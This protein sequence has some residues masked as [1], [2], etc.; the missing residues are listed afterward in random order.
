[1]R[2]VHDSDKLGVKVFMEL[3]SQAQ[4]KLV[5]IHNELLINNYVY[6]IIELVKELA[7]VPFTKLY[8]NITVLYPETMKDDFKEL[9]LQLID[10]EVLETMEDVW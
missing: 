5:T 6:Q 9:I 1:M 8:D 10:Y 7:P 2:K 3:P 4:N